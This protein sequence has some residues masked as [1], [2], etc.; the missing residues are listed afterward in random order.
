[1]SVGINRDYFKLMYN[2]HRRINKKEKIVGWYTTTTAE[3][4]LINDNSSLIQDF[5]SSE[6]ENSVH[7]VVGT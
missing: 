1:M 7:L 3:G 2:F 4:A 5:Y 6:C